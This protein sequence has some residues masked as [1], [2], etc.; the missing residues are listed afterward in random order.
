MGQWRA[1]ATLVRGAQCPEKGFCPSL[2][3]SRRLAC[4]DFARLWCACAPGSVQLFHA[5]MHGEGTPSSVCL[6]AWVSAQPLSVRML[7]VSSVSR[8]ACPL[9]SVRLHWCACAPCALAPTDWCASRAFI[10]ALA[11]LGHAVI[12]AFAR[13]SQC[14]FENASARP[15]AYDLG[16]LPSTEMRLFAQ[17][18]MLALHRCGRYTVGFKFACA[19]FSVLLRLPTFT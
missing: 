5:P 6:P 11:R 4:R 17:V 19:S 9:W 8:C 10:G 13:L 15:L 1:Y 14:G 16:V 18:C 2:L 7:R 3:F 12:G